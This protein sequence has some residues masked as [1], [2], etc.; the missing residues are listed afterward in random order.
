MTGRG[1]SP[2]SKS[3][4]ETELFAENGEGPLCVLAPLGRR[5]LEPADCLV[6][7]QVRI[8]AVD[9]HDHIPELEEEGS[10]SESNQADVAEDGVDSS[11]IR[12][13]IDVLERGCGA[14][15]RWH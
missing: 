2:T 15:A 7:V 4:L 1:A 3:D 8:S 9:G 13:R 11:S 12:W 10:G 6:K 14:S 5:A